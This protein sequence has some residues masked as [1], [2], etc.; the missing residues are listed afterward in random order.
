MPRN[1]PTWRRPLDFKNLPRDALLLLGRETMPS[2]PAR[3]RM[4]RKSRFL[5]AT[6]TEIP[7]AARAMSA[8]GQTQPSALH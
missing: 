7:G 3:R 2:Q 5:H 4:E 1:R 6:R 8:T